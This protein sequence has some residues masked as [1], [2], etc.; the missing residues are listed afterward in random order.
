MVWEKKVEGKGE[1]MT[2]DK[3]KEG[4][5]E[6]CESKVKIEADIWRMGGEVKDGRGSNGGEGK[7]KAGK[8]RR[9]GGNNEGKG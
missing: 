8:W 5:K 2:R 3:M 1:A 9:G 6:G 4:K 7:V